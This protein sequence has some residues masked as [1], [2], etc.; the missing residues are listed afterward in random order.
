MK[1]IYLFFLVFIF[2]SVLF[3][4]TPRETTIRLKT[5]FNVD[6]KFRLDDKA[7]YETAAY[8]DSHWRVLNLPH[9]WGIEGA[10]DVRN[11]AGGNGAY[12]PGGIGWY[13]KSFGLPDSLKGKRLIIQ[14]DGVYMNSKV[15]I[16]GRFLGQ[17]PNGSSTFQYDLTEHIQ[18]GKPNI[19]AV[20]VDHSLQPSSRWYS[21]SGI[22]RNV[23]LIATN[24]VH[25][26]N[27]AGVFVSYPTVSK[28]EAEVSVRYDIIAN[29]FPESEFR[30]WRRNI[31]ANKRAMKTATIRTSIFDKKGKVVATGFI[32]KTL[33]DYN[34]A[35]FTHSISVKSPKL[36]SAENPDTYT[37]KS[38]LEYDGDVVDDYSVTIGIRKIEF[39]AE[40][41]M[42]V[43]GVQEKIKGICVHQDA[44]SLGVAVPIGVWQERLKK[45]KDMGCNA[46][47]PSHHPFAP[48][49]YDLCDK[50]GFYVMDEAFDEW[51]KGYNWGITE[52]SYGKVPYGYHLYFNQWAETDLRAMIRRD[53][54]HPS[55]VMYSIGNEIPNQRTPDGVQIAKSLQDICH[56]E[57]PTRVVTTAVDFVED[58]NRNGFLSVPDIAG[59][60]YVDRYNGDQ[61]YAPEK[62]KYPKRL[63]LGAETYHDTRHWLA[64][65]NHDYVIGEFVWVGYD[66]LGEDGVWPKHGWDA[67]II[68]MADNPYPEYYLRKSYWSKD[69]VVH[70]AIET[71]ANRKSEWHPRKAAAHWNHQ[72]NGN[73]L[74]PLFVYSNCDEVELRIND[75]LIGRKAVD[76]NL[77]YAK[78][79]VPFKAGKVRA[80]GYR[81]NKQVTE[82]TLRTAGTA[83]GLHL[84]ASKT[85]LVADSEDVLRLAVTVVDNNG[86][87]VPDA[88]NEIKVELSGPARLRGL[89]N[90]SQSDT[91]AFSS[92][93]RKAFGGRLLATIQATGE[94]GL[95]KMKVTSPGLQPAVYTI[96]PASSKSS[97]RN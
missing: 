26:N 87:V 81:N 23:W 14:F 33:G 20:R 41:G 79:E 40:K 62:A 22:Y 43:N 34:E 58:A 9:D 66:Y 3:G 78:W 49:F 19:I 5:K 95:V 8:D 36:W 67:G 84:A 97:S 31:D 90:G 63:I 24:Q 64:V 27:Y 56:S 61:M 91:T 7:G 46:I 83:T 65:R 38:T 18:F 52:N 77:Y 74:L 21:G 13:R 92:K 82:H 29:A 86:V 6:W 68:D 96:K 25:F 1:H 45:L 48:E 51:N 35:S 11:P 85:E 50:M 10:F 28:S 16:N 42:L 59:Y 88:A 54:N 93:S 94:Q 39:T 89:D 15:Y 69:P 4:Q 76:K 47:R 60:N 32:N 17:Y 55:V 73:Y 37:L 57:D 72:W 70:I 71:S 44:G 2:P 53:R 30:W 80:T 12:L 75:S